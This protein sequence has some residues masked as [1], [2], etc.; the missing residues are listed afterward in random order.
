MGYERVWV[1]RMLLK[2]EKG[3]KELLKFGK[4]LYHTF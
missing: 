3:P 2:I 4:K 1:A